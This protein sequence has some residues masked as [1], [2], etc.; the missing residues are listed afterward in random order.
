MG[1]VL[2]GELAAPLVALSLVM[3]AALVATRVLAPRDG[4]AADPARD[5]DGREA[6]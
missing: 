5:A 2:F 4:D 1:R 3:L 6:R